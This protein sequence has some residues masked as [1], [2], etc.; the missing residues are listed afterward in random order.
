[1]Q[2]LPIDLTQIIAVVFRLT[3]TSEFD[4]QLRAGSDP[5]KTQLPSP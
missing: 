4:A 5:S 1:M 3:D 2:V